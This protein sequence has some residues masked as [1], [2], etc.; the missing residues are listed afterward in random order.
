M[1][2]VGCISYSNRSYASGVGGSAC[3]FKVSIENRCFPVSIVS[4]VGAG[5]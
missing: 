3:G 2:K 1:R 5:V 4:K